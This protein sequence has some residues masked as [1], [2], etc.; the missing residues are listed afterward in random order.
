MPTNFSDIHREH[1]VKVEIEAG[2]AL[3]F[4]GLLA[5]ALKSYFAQFPELLPRPQG[6]R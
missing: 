4:L 1:H 6:G 5:W 3:G 2:I